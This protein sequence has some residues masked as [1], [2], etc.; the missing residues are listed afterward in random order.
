MVRAMESPLHATGGITIVDGPLPRRRR[1]EGRRLRPRR[2][3]GFGPR[4]RGRT[5]CPG[6][7]I[8]KA[9]SRGDVVVIRSRARGGPGMREMLAVTGA[10]GRRGSTRYPLLTD[11][12]F[13][14]GT[15]ACA[16]ATSRPK[17]SRRPYRL[18]RG[19]RPH[20][21]GH[22]RPQL[23]PAGGRRRAGIPARWAGSRSRGKF[24]EGV[25]AKYAKLVH[26]ASTG[27]YCG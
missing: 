20:P 15:T 25:L 3:R 12:R 16:S 1:G 17:L 7:A 18:A 27:A 23:R 4:L 11:G 24:T 2:L 21:R 6:R 5:G 8:E 26:S 22:R 19:R 14:G 13:S 10:I 9:R